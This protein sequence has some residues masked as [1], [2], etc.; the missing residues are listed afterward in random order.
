MDD[1][2]GASPI[3][4]PNEHRD[5]PDADIERAGQILAGHLIKL[6]RRI[7]PP[8]S[9]RER[10]LRGI[11]VPLIRS[12][13]DRAKKEVVNTPPQARVEFWQGLTARAAELPRDMRIIILKLD[14]LG[15]FVVALPALEQLR[16]AFQEA[17]ITLVCGS[18]NRPWAEQCGLFDNVVTFDFFAPTNV[19]GRG[20]GEAQ[21]ESFRALPLGSYDL[22]VDL[23]HDPDTR[24]LLAEVEAK[25]RVGF[26][27]PFAAGGNCLDIALPD[28]ENLSVG[29][30]TGRPVHAEL[31]LVLLASAVIATFGLR[32]HPATR[33][34]RSAA[35][36]KVAT[37][38]YAILAPGAGSPIRLWSADHFVTVAR[39]LQERHGLDIIIV[40]GSRERATA[41]AIASALS[42]ERVSNLVERLP[43]IDLPTVI[44]GASLYVGLDT[45]T[46]H[47]AAALGVPTVAVIS[48]VPNLE[49]WHTAG[50]NVTVVA[51]RVACSPCYLVHPE[52]CPYGV[53]CLSS[54]TSGHI[55]PACDALLQRQQSHAL[56]QDAG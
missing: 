47:L 7:A 18:W 36:Q 8:G 21:F 20:P 55:I 10:V 42:P 6:R 56:A 40:G 11:Y 53:I 28:T 38:S 30:G 12:L 51:G 4:R 2:P 3:N 19:E 34:V 16:T 23:R 26:C 15:D 54:I 9:V 13:A 33:L 29:L 24:L 22:A 52:Q 41:Q 35:A 48:G 31:R 46:T 45:G 32:Q 1:M 49:V 43:L 5:G 14:H 27:A 25:F 17:N 39:A 37:R 50:H 44:S